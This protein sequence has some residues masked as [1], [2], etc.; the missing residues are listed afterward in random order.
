MSLLTELPGFYVTVSIKIS[1]LTELNPFFRSSYRDFAPTEL[2]FRSGRDEIVR[3]TRALL[4]YP[5]RVA[6][7]IV[8][9]FLPSAADILSV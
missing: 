4:C 9:A 8:G 6:P 3:L 5:R 7:V 2:F 1:L